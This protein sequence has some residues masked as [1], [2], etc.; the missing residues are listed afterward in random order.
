M[1]VMSALSGKECSREASGKPS[2]QGKV[3]ALLGSFRTSGNPFQGLEDAA[4]VGNAQLS[5]VT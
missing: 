3:W 2:R 4:L 5:D 1:L